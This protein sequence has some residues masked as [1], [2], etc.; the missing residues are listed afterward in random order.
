MIA[1]ALRYWYFIALAALVA[2]IGAQQLRIGHAQNQLSTYKLEAAEN[3]RINSELARQ[4]SERRQK[5]FDDEAAAARVEKAELESNVA[6]LADTADGLRGSLAEFQRRAKQCPK[7]AIGGKSEPSADPVDLL[8]IL[9]QRADREAA[10]LAEFA[11]R[12]RQA[13][14]SCERSTDSIANRSKPQ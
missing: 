6:Q 13:G 1:L 7:V 4:E 12:L 10:T 5:V 11:D 2:M 8:A 14:A 3:A 9:Y